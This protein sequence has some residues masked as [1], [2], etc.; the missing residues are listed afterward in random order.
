MSETVTVWTDGSCINNGTDRACSGIGVYYSHDDPRNYSSALRTDRH[1]NNRAEL[2]AILY[3]L[4]MDFNEHHIEVK[5]DSMYSIRCIVE[6]SAAWRERGWITSK[7]TPVESMV[8]IKYI[9][10]IV[11]DREQRGL[12][13]TFTHV[14]GHST[15]VENNAAD[16]LAR[17]G[18]SKSEE[19]G[20]LK[21]LRYCGV[22]M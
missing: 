3:A 11:A 1:T 4:C 18:A 16:S 15:N 17:S 6:Y 8:V 19:G 5:T 13:T 22:P 9:L 2:I 21:L 10:S 12:R 20:R 7:G 14:R